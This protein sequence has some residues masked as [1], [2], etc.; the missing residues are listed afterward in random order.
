[1]YNVQADASIA[2]NSLTAVSAATS[3]GADFNSV[4]TCSLDN[5]VDGIANSADDVVLYPAYLR[6]QAAGDSRTY[7]WDTTG[8]VDCNLGV[9]SVVEQ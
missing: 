3:C 1:M 5:G 8:L 9:A 4:T 7:S 6:I 2:D